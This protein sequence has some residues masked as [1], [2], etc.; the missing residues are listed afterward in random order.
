M[1]M[2]LMFIG[3]V[4]GAGV[5]SLLFARDYRNKNQ[6]PAVAMVPE[7]TLSELLVTVTQM[8]DALQRGAWDHTCDTAGFQ[9]EAKALLTQVNAMAATLLGFID[10]IP[11]P[12]I[13]VDKEARVR[14][15]NQVCREQGFTLEEIKGLTPYDLD[16]TEDQKR[17]TALAKE[18]GRTGVPQTAQIIV[19]SPTGDDLIEEYVVGP[20][21]D[22]RGQVV[23]VMWV[24]F[25]SSNTVNKAKKVGKYQAYEAADIERKLREGLGV[26]ILS[27]SFKPEPHDEDTEEVAI[28]YDKIGMT[29]AEAT[30]G[31]KAY[32]DEITR[33]LTAVAGGDL[34]QTITREFIGD[35]GPI[36]TAINRII[37]VLNET[38]HGIS[39]VAT[40][41]G[42]GSA[43]LSANAMDLANGTAQQMESVREVSA[44]VTRVDTQATDSAVIAQKAANLSQTSK[45]NATIANTEMSHLLDA[46]GRIS[47][48]SDKIALMLKTIESI[49]FQTNLLA[50]NAAVEAARAG[51]M[52][53]GFAVVAEEVRSLAGRSATAAKE[54]AS[55][56]AESMSNVEDGTRTA[57]DV[58]SSLDKIVES[59][60]DVSVAI[61][62]IFAATD[63][64]TMAIH[65]INTDLD[66]ISAVAQKS[67]YNSEET[68]SAAEELDSQVTILKDKVAFFTTR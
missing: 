34:T 2:I 27:F 40:G 60:T 53:R 16:P 33:V 22:A 5:T 39:L 20:L 23:A 65:S 51:E 29:L 41:V 31:I 24:N 46:M 54:T 8:G 63:S 21:R 19:Q 64:Q 45:Q 57:S 58:A 49:A 61:D 37:H 6:L 47:Q 55:L 3:V 30:E 13:V 10:Q 50:L 59:I 12:A 38:V 7:T 68:A 1:N 14:Y 32:M 17:I 43:Q 25:D 11:A 26:G 28:A 42:S 44:N 62:E 52:G 36:Q 4:L 15:V 9:G 66:Q 48:S 35:F 67:A 18:V 56:I